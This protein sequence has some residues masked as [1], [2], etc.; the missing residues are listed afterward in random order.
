MLDKSVPPKTLPTVDGETEY[1]HKYSV[2]N[3]AELTTI[4]AE[5]F[6]AR[7]DLDSTSTDIWIGATFHA[8]ERK[9]SRDPCC[10]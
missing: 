8:K 10:Y 1:D 7:I 9:L 3:F 2:A 6:D 5:I 4:A